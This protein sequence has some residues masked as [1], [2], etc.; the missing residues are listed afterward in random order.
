MADTP[1]ELMTKAQQMYSEMDAK[2]TLA[3]EILQRITD[4]EGQANVSRESLANA[5]LAAKAVEEIAT[6]ARDAQDSN[7]QTSAFMEESKAH[8]ESVR[9]SINNAISGFASKGDEAASHMR[10]I[11][12]LAGSAASDAATSKAS[13]SEATEALNE[14]KS[15]SKEVRQL[16]EDLDK[17]LERAASADSRVATYERELATLK[18]KCTERLNEITGLLPGATSVGL[19]S[20]FND[21]RKLFNGPTTFWQG[22]FLG[23]LLLLSLIAGKGLW[24]VIALSGSPPTFEQTAQLWLAR[25]PVAGV[26]VWLALHAGREAAM[27]KRLEEDYG[28]K[29]VISASFVGFQEQMRNMSDHSIASPL[30]KLCIDVLTTI[31]SPPGRIYDKHPLVTSPTAHAKEAAE[32]VS[33]IVDAAK[34]TRPQ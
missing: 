3:K 5:I 29:Q 17:L 13:A 12:A 34:S 31:G 4:I 33:A 32:A 1:E 14:A 25:L 9:T 11:E 15:A 2:L 20:A 27:A 23:S 18:T 6:R 22:V 30:S 8:V 7:A 28:Y 26:L 19:A 24:E 16:Q 10:S 21:R